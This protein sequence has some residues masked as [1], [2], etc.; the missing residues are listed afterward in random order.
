MASSHRLRA[1]GQLHSAEVMCSKGGA[2]IYKSCSLCVPHIL[3][4]RGS[5]CDSAESGPAPM[6]MHKG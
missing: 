1:H 5:Q 3:R 6:I 4:G 2:Y